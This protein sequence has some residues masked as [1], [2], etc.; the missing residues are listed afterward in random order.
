MADQV[1]GGAIRTAIAAGPDLVELAARAERR[2]GF[3][4]TERGS[5][6]S[7]RHE[8]E[9]LRRVD[10]MME[11]D[12]IPD[13]H[14]LVYADWGPPEGYQVV[15]PEG[16]YLGVLADELARTGHRA[17]AARVRSLAGGQR[18]G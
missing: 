7:Y 18:D 4:S 16:V 5:G 2:E 15:V 13:G 9:A 10:D 14:V 8:I 6:V 3:V 1:E 17:T 12:N 11:G